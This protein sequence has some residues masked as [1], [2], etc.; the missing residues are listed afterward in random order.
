MA[1]TDLQRRILLHLRNEGYTAK[2]GDLRP[3]L[4]GCS[5]SHHEIATALNELNS[6]KLLHDLHQGDHYE[7]KMGQSNGSGGVLGID[8][9]NINLRINTVGLEYLRRAEQQEQSTEL[10]R[11]QSRVFWIVFLLGAIG[12]AV[13]IAHAVYDLVKD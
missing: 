12:G 2:H 6:S 10:M 9:F 1:P 4:R 8:D 3:F 5:E 11:K 7:W 13:G